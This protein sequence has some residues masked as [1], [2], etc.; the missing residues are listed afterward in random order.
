MKNGTKSILLRVVVLVSVLIIS[1]G[2]K[3]DNTGTKNQTAPFSEGEVIISA[4]E[5]ECESIQLNKV[6]TG[7]FRTIID[8]VYQS[9]QREEIA[10]CPK[11]KMFNGVYKK[12]PEVKEEMK[13]IH[14]E[15]FA[16]GIHQRN[17]LVYVPIGL[18]YYQQIWW[19]VSEITTIDVIERE[20]IPIP[21]YGCEGMYLE[22][23]YGVS[24]EDIEMFGGE[25]IE[26]KLCSNGKVFQG[27]SDAGIPMENEG[28]ISYGHVVIE[29]KLYRAYTRNFVGL[30]LRETISN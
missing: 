20:G 4:T 23:V 22:Q 12:T 7:D 1:V 19:F 10:F 26:K 29:G 16:A 25:I 27:L 6:P 11:G 9:K 13:S 3:K 2:C 28:T 24:S 8:N 30:I 15:A 18:L 5:V 17:K 21:V 14:L